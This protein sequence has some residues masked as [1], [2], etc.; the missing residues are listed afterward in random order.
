MK[1]MTNN[2]E[3]TENDKNMGKKPDICNECGSDGDCIIEG[4]WGGWMCDVCGH[5]FKLLKEAT[6]AR[7]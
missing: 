5:E 3:T 4:A 1:M 2:P 7:K 6:D